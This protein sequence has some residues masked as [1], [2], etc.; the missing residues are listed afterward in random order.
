MVYETNNV[1]DI[2]R[3]GF[4]PQEAGI[5]REPVRASAMTEVSPG[6]RG[7]VTLAMNL[8][9]LSKDLMAHPVD[10]EGGNRVGPVELNGTLHSILAVSS[11]TEG[12][13][14]LTINRHGY[15]H[16]DKVLKAAIQKP[17]EQARKSIDLSE[18]PA[19]HWITLAE[20]AQR[21]RQ[22]KE[23]VQKKGGRM[24]KLFRRL[25]PA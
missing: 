24:A 19:A 7:I 4:L 13:T 25:R 1:I 2:N 14:T 18:V 12:V 11:E 23:E 17:G 5:L 6:D 9:Q 21:M 10:L 3:L 16:A 22:Q 8:D 20:A 15:P